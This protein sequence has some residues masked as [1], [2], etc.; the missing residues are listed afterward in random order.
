MA[1]ALTRM[2]ARHEVLRTTF[3]ERD[4]R[5]VQVVG[6]P[7]AVALPR[8]D[9][10]ALAA[11]ARTA[12]LDRLCVAES[13][14]R[15][16]LQTGPLLAAT[17]VRLAEEE[18]ALLLNAHH[19]VCDGWSMGVLVRESLRFYESEGAELAPLALQYADF[20]VWQREWL[21]G[22]RLEG[23]LA[24]WRGRLAG[25]EPL[26][27]PF[28]RPRPAQR[29][30]RGGTVFFAFPPALEGRVRER[31][32]DDKSTSFVVLLAAFQALLARLTGQDDV[33]VGAPVANRSR[34]ELEALLGFFVNTLVLRGDLGGDPGFSELLARTARRCS[35]LSTTRTFPSNGWSRSSIPSAAPRGCPSSW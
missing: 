5:P 14:R 33:T 34:S 7:F 10:S 3:A 21:E 11:P 27:L 18:H 15:F 28:D 19:V 24:Y 35:A 12:E 13:L 2:V 26:A 30:T 29:S 31:A 20:A 23:Q 16:D 17:L 9:L 22:D 6:E 1:R 8:V 4:A 32:R 25:V